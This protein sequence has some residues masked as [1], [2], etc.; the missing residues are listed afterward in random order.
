MKVILKQMSDLDT[1]YWD[2]VDSMGATPVKKPARRPS[3]TT[4]KKSV[5]AVRASNAFANSLGSPQYTATPVTAAS[6][7]MKVQQSRG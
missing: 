3:A 2:V 6:T 4:T 5:N 1:E 7:S